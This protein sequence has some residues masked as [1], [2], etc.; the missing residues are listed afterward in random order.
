M[1]RPPRHRSRRQ[2]AVLIDTSISWG[3]GII[4]GIHSY[5]RRHADWR[6]FVEARG[7]R[8]PVEVPPGWK[9]A[10]IIARVGDPETARSLQALSLPV[11]NVSALQL[12]GPQF[13]RVAM[14][15]EAAGE[16]AV[17]Y[18]LERG[19]RHFAYLSLLGLECVTRQHRAFAG[20][21][22][23]AGCHCAEL[24]IEVNLRTQSPTQNLPI[25]KLTAWLKA[26]PK[27]VAILTWNGGRE[28]IDCCHDAGLLVPEEVALLSGSNDELL[29]E[30]CDIPISAI[31]QPVEQIG[32][33][34]AALLDGMM[35]RRKPVRSPAAIA[36]VSVI[37]RR[38]TDTLAISDRSVAAALSF[39]RD[40]AHRAL[41]VS[42][43]AAKIGVSRRVLERRFDAQL[44]RS[45]A[46]YIR[47]SHLERAKTFL[48]Q[49]DRPLS[50]IAE[51]S[52][53]SSQQYLASLMR[54]EV[55]MSPHNYRLHTRP[56]FR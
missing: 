13:P 20:A 27:P 30:V 15:V 35:Q 45:P 17:K 19:F 7:H 36:P 26:L 46:E 34:A 53:V 8:D 14:D 16:M 9:G 31:Q 49:T 55:G 51:A 3:R 21:V 38:S 11:V 18:F 50:D 25:K 5:A 2:I 54:R 47:H 43:V 39:I 42:E 33:E 23:A 52:G 40:N 10:G 4:V 41:R 32:M 48:T 37:S 29:C 28:V 1:A 22:Q 12:P 56:G 24:G 44:Q 6:I